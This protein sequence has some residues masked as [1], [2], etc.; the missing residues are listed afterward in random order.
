MSDTAFRVVEI[1]VSAEEAARRAVVVRQWLAERG[2]VTL[3]DDNRV[4]VVVERVVHHAFGNYDPPSCPG[5]GAAVD[6]S[7]HHDLVEPWFSAGFEG[8]LTCVSCGLSTLAGDLVG[9]WG[10]HV[11]ELAV[12]FLN[13]PPLPPV[14]VAELGAVMGPRPRVV[15][16]RT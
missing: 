4:D 10:F 13:W 16:T 12:V 11:G 14:V 9:P 7:A 2:L 1:S 5:C 6:D 15:L 8:S 3:D